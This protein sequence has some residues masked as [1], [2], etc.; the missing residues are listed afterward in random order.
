MLKKFFLTLALKLSMGS[1]LDNV[2]CVLEKDVYC[3]EWSIVYMSISSNRFIVFLKSSV[4]LTD[5]LKSCS[6]YY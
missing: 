4:L 5:V 2:P 6:I 1:I 3:A